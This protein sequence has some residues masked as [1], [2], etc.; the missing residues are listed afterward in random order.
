MSV[1]PGTKLGPYEILQPLGAGGMGEVYRA[2]DTKLDREVAIKILPES[3]ANDPDRLARFEREA[4]VLAALNHPNI[5]HI[6][7][8]EDRALVMELVEGET[9]KGPLPVETALHYAKQIAD[10]LEAAH[11]K[12]V[13]HRD[14]KPANVKVTPEG[15]VKVLDF[16][17]ATAVDTPAPS[18]DAAISPTLT[19]RATQ[20]GM[21]LGTAAYMSP[22]QARAQAVD[23]RADIWAFGA[24]LFEMLSGKQAFEGDSV[25]DIL[26]SVVKLDPDWSALP[27][28]TPPAIVRLIQ[29]CLTKDRKQRLQAIGEARIA[30][31]KYLADPTSG[32][33]ASQPTEPHAT[34]TLPWAIAA[35]LVLIGI[36]GWVAWRRATRVVEQ[37]LRPLV[38]LDV[39]LGPDVSLNSYSG[40]DVILSPDGQ[41]LVFVSR[42][43]LFTRRLDQPNAIEL[44]ETE[45]A[46]APFFSPDG[47]W[48]AFFAQG[49]LKKVALEGGTAIA[50]CSASAGL[51]GSWG[52]DGNIIAALNALGLSQI[53][54]GGGAPIPITKPDR[55]H[56]EV[57]HRWPQILPGGKAVLFTASSSWIGGGD[58]ATI[59]VMSL[60]NHQRKRL[61]QGGTFGRYLPSGHLVYVN[62]GTLFAVPFD[63]ER[64]EEQGTPSAV[65]EHIAYNPRG[66]YS[67]LDFSGAS[68]G[69]GT[70]LYRSGGVSGVPVTVQ[71]LDRTGSMQPLLAKAGF[72]WAPRLSPDG[73]RL[74]MA[75]SEGPNSDTRVYELRRDTFTRLTVPGGQISS[76]VWS[77]DGRYLVFIG[78]GMFWIRS[79]GAGQPQPLTRSKTLQAPWS[80]TPDGKRLA[81]MEL[82]DGYSIW[83]VSVE[84]D[85]AGLRAGEPELFLKTSADERHASFSSDGRWL[86]YTSN[87]SGSYQ[88]YV[89][90]FPDKGGKWQISNAGGAYPVWSRKGQELFFRTLDNQIMVAG[91][92]VNGDSFAPEK[93]R[94]WSEKL[95]AN[96]PVGNPSFDVAPD[97]KRVVALMPAEG[98]DAQEHHVI[99]L[100]NFY[101]ELRR[102][103]PVGK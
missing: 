43:R 11:E 75:V 84:S 6:Y 21:I 58:D 98:P 47:Q 51:G 2:K 100:Q 88:V 36:A 9:L 62:R 7:G 74:A 68:S 72:Y 101:D 10:A 14:L 42:G 40:A 78:T 92:R 81:F 41:R 30:I 27:P 34:S 26:A 87:E 99:F 73:Q 103:A 50:L 23:R 76:P 45:G 91:Y 22:E 12:G 96:F 77:P 17:L 53:S 19:M 8:V 56:G 65:L 64:L 70:L 89:R 90:A 35:V 46:Y 5:A 24:V 80:F 16:G 25:T 60:A 54:S 86:A 79:D 48:V 97:G 4:K 18:G 102:R 61:Q 95:L 39:D 37:A 29:R 49:K 31:E 67:Q 57:V 13:V 59:E 52:E 20:A 28:S 66:A 55:E 1:A 3:F 32:N 82:A 71:W 85:A 38:R 69:H 94:V 93:P 63:L 44:G 15:V 33:E 83:T